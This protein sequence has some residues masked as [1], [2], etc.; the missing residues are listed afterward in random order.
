MTN[1]SEFIYLMPGNW[2]ELKNINS[3]KTCPYDIDN[4]KQ[5]ILNQVSTRSDKLGFINISFGT[6]YAK[7]NID[8][9]TFHLDKKKFHQIADSLSSETRHPIITFHGTNSLDTVNSILKHGYIIPDSNDT[10][11]VIHKTHGSA[12]GIGI[13][14][15][16]F[17]DKSLS[18]TTPDHTKNVYILINIVF[19]GVMKMIPPNGK[20]G[21]DNKKPVNGKYSDGSNTH[22]VFGLDQLVSADPMKIIPI[23]VMKINIQ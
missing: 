16:V 2:F 13:Y 7:T 18:Y 1:N 9:I 15:S 22:V 14:S 20:L 23:G 21:V 10:N 5:E 4:L 12:Y 19:L 3:E 11:V 17:F 6:K 8:N